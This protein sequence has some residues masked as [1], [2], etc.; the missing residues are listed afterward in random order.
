MAASTK[1][2]DLERSMA[3]ATCR[4]ST[5]NDPK[6]SGILN[7]S[8]RRRC[9]ALKLWS[10]NQGCAPGT[11]RSPVTATRCLGLVSCKSDFAVSP[12]GL[13]RPCACRVH[14]GCISGLIGS[15]WVRISPWIPQI[16]RIFIDSFNS[17]PHK[18]Y[19]MWMSAR[20]PACCKACSFLF[21]FLLDHDVY[22]SLICL[23]WLLDTSKVSY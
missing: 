2:W 8:T 19:I 7:D 13:L 1:Q 5:Q 17:S 23:Q 16:H 6:V 18:D 21:I 14:L 10:F 3:S 12:W 20:F 22:N 11:R 15:F 4:S 9:Q